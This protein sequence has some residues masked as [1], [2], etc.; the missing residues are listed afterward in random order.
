MTPT[1]GIAED[2]MAIDSDKDDSIPPSAQRATGDLVPYRKRPASSSPIRSEIRANSLNRLAI[3][4]D[5]ADESTARASEVN[6][7]TVHAGKDTARAE[8]GHERGTSDKDSENQSATTPLSVKRSATVTNKN[9]LAELRRTR[10]LERSRVIKL[11]AIGLKEPPEKMPAQ[12]R[13]AYGSIA[14]DDE[15]TISWIFKQ[16]VAEDADFYTASPTPYYTACS[17]LAKARAFGNATSQYSAAQFLHNWRKQGTPFLVKPVDRYVLTQTQ[18]SQ[19]VDSSATLHTDADNAFCFAWDMCTRYETMLA[20]VNIGTRWAFALLGKAYARKVDEIQVADRL[21]SNDRTRNRYG[22]GQ[23]RTEAITYLVHLVCQSPSKSDHAAFRYRLKRATR[24]FDIV[25]ALGW[26]SLLLIPHEEVSNHWLERVL[27]KNQRDVF[28]EL[29]KRERPEICTASR[30]LEAW[31][32]PDGITGAPIA[33]KERLSI[34]AN[35]LATAV[36]LT[37]IPDSEAEDDTDSD[38]S[39]SI[40]ASPAPLRQMSVLELFCPVSPIG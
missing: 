13:M 6:T 38:A 7:M 18:M 28:L 2:R 23:A 25:Q 21:A 27:R 9:R 36:G 30:A 14:P 16:K 34:E 22:K 35:A 15:P 8:G 1:E 5:S 24:W 39:E 17:M 3:Q 29:V 31:L 12:E 20:A 11:E 10:K 40:P 19:S 37:E 4:E 33:G 26:G 32:G